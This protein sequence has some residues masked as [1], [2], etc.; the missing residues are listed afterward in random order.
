MSPAATCG[1]SSMR[2]SLGS[3]GRSYVMM[4]ADS[5]VRAL[6][7]TQCL[8]LSCML[9]HGCT[10]IA[11]DALDRLRRHARALEASFVAAATESVGQ[12]WFAER[13]KQTW[14]KLSFCNVSEMKHVYVLTVCCCCAGQ[15]GTCVPECGG[16]RRHLRH[17]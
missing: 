9:L 6:H 15:A 8:W 10:D 14:P 11:V 16:L 1:S 2:P 17:H 3:V 13:H 12:Q 7:L 4:L 5:L